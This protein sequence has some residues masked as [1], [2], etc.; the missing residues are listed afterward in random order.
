MLN[1]ETTKIKGRK[2]IAEHLTLTNIQSVLDFAY[3]QE[4]EVNMFWGNLIDNYFIT[5]P[6]RINNQRTT[7]KH[8]I[9][10]ETYDHSQSS[11]Y[12]LILTNDTE[13]FEW[14]LE[15]YQNEESELED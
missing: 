1:I 8:C 14:L 4:Y 3:K 13:Y 6:I 15:E 5:G 7:Y 2:Y 9:L 12:K 10:L 11:L